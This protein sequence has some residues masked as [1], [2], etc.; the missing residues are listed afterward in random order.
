[1]QIESAT[2]DPVELLKSA[3]GITPEALNAIDVL[4][5]TRELVFTVIDS[6]VLT[7]A[8]IYESV[9]AAPPV[10]VDDCSK[11]DA[12]AN[13]GLQSGFLA[14]RDNLCVK[15]SIALE[16]AED[17]GLTGSSATTLASDTASA[18]IAFVHFDFARGEGRGS[19]ALSGDA[20]SDFEK[21][22]GH[23]ATRQPRQ[24][25]HVTGRQIEREVTKNLTEFML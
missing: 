25:G 1:M 24:M 16:D 12:T 22:R 8:N 14:V 11:R 18:E 19:F 20:L 15:A 6:E 17:D 3:L 9:I 5:A 21:D 13:N 4:C 7:V 10:R 23:A 2:R